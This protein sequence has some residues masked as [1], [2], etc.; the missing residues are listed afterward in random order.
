MIPIIELHDA[1][2]EWQKLPVLVDYWTSPE[3]VEVLKK[4]EEYL[5]I[6]IGNEVG[7][8]VSESDFKTGYETAIKRMREAGTCSSHD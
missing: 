7:A 4:H 5:I 8:Q 3:V 2:G 6:N 1:T